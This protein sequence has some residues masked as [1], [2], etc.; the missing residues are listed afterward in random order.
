M[1]ERVTPHVAIAGNPN[2]GKSTIFNELTGLR[3][4]VANYPGKTVEKHVGVLDVDTDEE[5]RVI[6]LPGTYSLNPHSPDEEISHDVLMGWS[7]DTPRPCLIVAVV[8][9]SNLERNLFFITQLLSLGIPMIVALNMVDTCRSSGVEIDVA[10]LEQRLGVPVVP[11]VGSRGEGIPVLKDRIL[12]QMTTPLIPRSVIQLPDAAARAVDLVAAVF[13]SNG[14]AP[15]ESS[16]GEA[17]RSICTENS[18]FHPRFAGA[19]EPLEAAILNARD[20]LAGAG[21]TWYAVEAEAGYRWIESVMADTRQSHEA[22]TT[23]GERADHWLTHR[24]VGPCFLGLI[25]LTIFISIFTLAKPPMDWI[26][27]CFGSLA[28]LVV[29]IIPPGPL[30]SLLTDGVITGVGGI[31]VFLPQIMLLFFFI[32]ILEDSGYTARAALIMDRI[33]SRVGLHGRAFIPL[34]SSFA[35]AVP[36]VMGTRMIDNARDRLLTIFV[37]PFMCCS[38][39]WPVYLLLAGAFSPSTLVLGIIPLPALT[40]VS[41][42]LLG[43]V[44]AVATSA[45]FHKTI[46][47]GMTSTPAMELPRYRR[48]RL[49]MV[50]LAM[51]ERSLLFVKKAGT[52]ILAMSIIMWALTNYPHRPGST[53]DQ[54]IRQSYAGILGRA[55]EPFIAPI[56]FD[57][58]IGISILS[59]FV[60]REVFVS[61]MATIYGANLSDPHR[62]ADLQAHLRADVDPATGLPFFTPLRALSIMIFFALS[63]QCV[64]TIAV[65]RR[66]TNNWK[67]TLFQLAYMTGL[68]W[69]ACFMLWQGG[70]FLGWS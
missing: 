18:F 60:A 48:P 62:A 40:L 35:C 38:A 10:K 30:R 57:W 61:S 68:A 52:I 13:Q 64:S 19:R 59:S 65:V 31:M 22:R 50:L 21:M 66:E 43:I 29:K 2:S 5:I 32:A 25:V 20:H 46:L 17:L 44:A 9:A 47:K 26:K 23:F 37:A 51:W 24:I 53:Q 15:P 33:M 6:D 34:F 27:H 67:W 70:R 55:L 56:G 42:I 12:R 69:L 28:V 3:Q 63:L 8:D 7:G 41:M 39:R 1:K 58:R 11:T 45:L 14:L 49:R 36:G 16:R 4:K 54:Q